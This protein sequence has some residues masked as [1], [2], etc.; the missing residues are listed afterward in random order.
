MGT[1]F[2]M[3]CFLLEKENFGVT[4]SRSCIQDILRIW[5]NML[6]LIHAPSQFLIYFDNIF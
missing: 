6:V 3:S 1:I 4:L 5:S 2:L